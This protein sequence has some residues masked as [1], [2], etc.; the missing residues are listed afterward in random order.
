MRRAV[1]L[2][3]AAVLAGLLA[4]VFASYQRDMR[5]ARARV[6]SGSQVAQTACGPIE[7]AT[8][9]EGPAVLAV[10]G[11]G[12]GFDQ[13]VD[14]AG[15]LAARGFRVIR[16]SRFGYLRTP[17]PADA[18]A[19][20]QADAHACLLDALGIEREREVTVHEEGRNYEAAGDYEL[21]LGMGRLKLIGVA[22]GSRFPFEV[23]VVSR[24]PDDTLESS[25]RFTQA[26]DEHEW[27]ARTEYRW[28]RG[29]SEW[30][31]SAEGAFNGLDNV[32]R[33]FQLSSDGQLRETPLPGAVARV[34]EDR[35]EIMGSY[36]RPLS[37][38]LTLKWT[39]GG[40]Y[41]QLVQAGA[42]GT[43]RTFYRPKGEL[44]AAW[45]V[46]PRT[47]VNMKLARRV[48]QLNF[49]DFLASVNLQDDQ[50]TAANPDLVPEQSW[51]LD[52]EA[53]RNLGDLGSTT[54]RLY[55][56]FIED[57]IDYVPIGE[58]GQ[59]PGNLDHA[60]VYGVEWR[61]TFNLDGIGWRGAR[62]DAEA[63]LQD[64]AVEDPL[65]GEHRHISNS[66]LRWSSVA[67]R[68]D[69]PGT[70]WAWGTGAS[71]QY[72]ALDYRLTEVGRLW[73]GPVWMNVYLENKD[74]AGM[75]VRATV[76]NIIGADS[77]WDRTVYTGRRTGPIAYT[78]VRDR[79]I[80][81]IFSF[82]VRG[83]F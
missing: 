35:Y 28:T 23:N 1:W 67:L 37:A 46:S 60:I 51:N 69:L 45:K 6:A 39:A 8:D 42:G 4:L 74:V 12:G 59:A 30:Q 9:G 68:H 20:A 24:M 40:E 18:S 41:S 10:H 21:E 56:R 25:E 78:E 76:S 31:L 32:S 72:N 38:N 13:A 66:L 15:P 53:A 52:I 49:F 57:I 61:G 83:K 16:P 44:S 43:T 29:K 36:G 54:V 63:Q 7:F 82:Q 71:Y 73:E 80:G 26:G 2:V 5:E 75:T 55:G 50:E 64:S 3:A 79:Q 11:A 77:M 62:F 34:E 27:I 33:L 81:P 17:L 65:T 48:G 58:T 22:R 19:A 14:L 47:D 70:A